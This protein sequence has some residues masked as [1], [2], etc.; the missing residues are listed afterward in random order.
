VDGMLAVKRAVPGVC[1]G[2]PGG[3]PD[4]AEEV[5]PPT[6]PMNQLGSQPRSPLTSLTA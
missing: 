2:M 6:F 3:M 5:D 4:E 1:G